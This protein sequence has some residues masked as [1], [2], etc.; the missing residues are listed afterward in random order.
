MAD[1]VDL[2]GEPYRAETIDLPS[3]AEGAVVATLVSRRAG[4]RRAVLHVHG[5]CDYFFHTVVADFWSARGYDFY[6]LDLRKHGR[7]LLP[8]QTPNMVLDLAEYFPDLDAAYRIITERDGHDRVV[9]SGHS[10]GALVTS[11]WLGDRGHGVSGMP[12][13]PDGR[14]RPD[15]PDRRG[16]DRVGGVE[17]LVLNSPWLDLNG[18]LWVRTVGSHAME[19]LGRLRP[20]Q[21]I[22]RTVSGLYGASLH[23]D[24]GGEWDFDLAWKPLE[25]WPVYAG[26]LRAVVRG[27]DR[28]H[29]GLRLTTPTLV[30]SSD[31][32]VRPHTWEPDV[33]RCD[34]VLDVELIAQW[35]HKISSHVTLVQVPG[36]LHDVML[37][38]QPAR[39]RVFEELSRWLDGFVDRGHDEGLPRRSDPET[40]RETARTTEPGA[41][42][43]PSGTPPGP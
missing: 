18:S 24:H 27:H 25:S 19:M 31:R 1:S 5:F 4:R 13:G 10:T 28:V 42:F 11:L 20:H 12:D 35:V 32:S 22:P 30:L 9:L 21:E 36:A 41:A 2:L 37:S 23:R 34:I 8:H 14:D 3:D 33:D 6:A 15:G 40:G 29:A 43:S 39:A 38:R 17:G 7:S 16:V 26:W